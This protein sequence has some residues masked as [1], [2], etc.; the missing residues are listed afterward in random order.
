MIKE[1][2]VCYVTAFHACEHERDRMRCELSSE[3]AGLVQVLATRGMAPYQIC[4]ELRE[5]GS[6][7]ATCS[8]IYYRW[9]Q[10]VRNRYE[11]D[12]DPISTVHQLISSC[13]N[14][15]SCLDVQSPTAIGFIT[16]IGRV[17]AEAEECGELFIDNTYKTNSSNLELFS[18]MTSVVGTG[19]PLSNLL[20]GQANENHGRQNSLI[21]FP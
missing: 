20:L 9:C 12:A 14:F 10:A 5:T 4:N 16:S 3:E 17:V 1:G 11:R 7:S 2:A 18:I 8:A 21:E 6:I 13:D 19:Y 15:T